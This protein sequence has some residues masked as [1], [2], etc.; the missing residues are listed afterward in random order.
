MVHFD[1]VNLLFLYSQRHIL[2]K[3]KKFDR[4]R[5]EL[6]AAKVLQVFNSFGKKDADSFA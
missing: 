4:T 1:N 3:F 6:Y 5:K 2:N